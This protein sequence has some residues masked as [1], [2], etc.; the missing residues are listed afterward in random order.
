MQP[1]NWRLRIL[2]FWERSDGPP[3]SLPEAL[4]AGVLEWWSTGVMEWCTL[5][6]LHPAKAHR[7]NIRRKPWSVPRLRGRGE[8]G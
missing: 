7:V 4:R 2:E 8:Q 3:A 5:S 6:G 1:V